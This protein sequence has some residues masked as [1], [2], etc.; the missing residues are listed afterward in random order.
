MTEK[1]PECELDSIPVTEEFVPDED[2]YYED[3]RDR[4]GLSE[5]SEQNLAARANKQKKLNEVI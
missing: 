4:Q 1:E 5:L 3:W 2:L